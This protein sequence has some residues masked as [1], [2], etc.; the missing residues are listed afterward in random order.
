VRPRK[1]IRLLDEDEDRR[2]ITRYLL[3]TNGFAVV[4]DFNCDLVI[5]TWPGHGPEM[6]QV[7]KGTPM[8]ALSKKADKRVF[9]IPANQ[10]LAGADCQPFQI[11]EAV[12]QLTARKRGPKK[13][14]LPTGGKPKPQPETLSA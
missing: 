14:C 13:G 1:K 6:E 12:R 7:P 9:E 10:C 2:G 5:A 11:L 8:L 3:I 4:E